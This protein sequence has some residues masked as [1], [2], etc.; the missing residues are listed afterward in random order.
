MRA[1]LAGF[2]VLVASTTAAAK[3]RVYKGTW[4]TTNRELDGT[5]TCVITPR[6]RD[7]WHGSFS[8]VWNG[9]E[10]AYE[11]DFKGPPD[12]L[13]GQA[14]IDGAQYEWSGWMTEGRSGTFK[15]EFWGNRY[16]GYFT[17]K[18]AD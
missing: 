13:R 8:G 4:V 12:K 9:Q 15:G 1:V 16:E 7:R 17:L 3:E 18:Q 5:L 11:V 6:G 14:T 2:L 10:F